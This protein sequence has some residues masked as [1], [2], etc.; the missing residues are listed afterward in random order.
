[1]TIN[2]KL[3]YFA[4]FVLLVLVFFVPRYF[5]NLRY[6]A[7]EDEILAIENNQKFSA[8]RF[9]TAPDFTHPGFWYVLMELP[10]KI[11]DINYGIFYYRLI[12]SLI[13]FVLI[14]ISLFYFK[15]KL[16]KTFLLLFYCFFLSN[17]YLVHL[18]IQHRMYALVLGI[19]ILYSFY[20]L[21]LT[22]REKDISIK[23]ATIM[24]FLAALGFFTNYSF[25]WLLPIWPLAYFLH[26]RTTFVFKR[27]VLFIAVLF[28]LISWFIPIFIRNTSISIAGNQ[29]TLPLTLRNV[30][31]LIGN[32]FG[33]ISRNLYTQ[34]V[35]W[36]VF[37]FFFILISI[38]LWKTLTRK[39]IYLKY[40]ISSVL[41][42]F[43]FFIL[44]VYLTGNSLLYA[45]TTIPFIVVLYAIISDIFVSGNEYI[46]SMVLV[47]IIMQISQF[48]IYFSPNEKFYRE[49]HLFDYKVNTLGYFKD[50]G[51][52]KNSCLVPVPEWNTTIAEF[53]LRDHVK[54]IRTNSISPSEL[55][56]QISF[57]PRVYLI[58]Q[59]SV[60]RDIV[61]RFYIEAFG[62]IP[63]MKLIE[64]YENQSLFIY[65]Q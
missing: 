2:K 18:T 20:W 48:F 8:I 62:E 61:N 56:Q 24:G 54:V 3:S 14:I 41:L 13:L 47:L 51:F 65:R 29:W 6:D 12:Q 25:I 9:I 15:N 39:D 57:C 10:T 43:S 64:K 44:A 46:K 60:N 35:N 45:R 28:S 23:E 50:Y 52:V 4:L 58:D 59:T 36:I 55:L 21:F 31:Q 22:K 53:F 11:L 38:V 7:L 37:P 16:P 27:M 32:Y 26:R 34:E 40:L 33:L 49:Y 30:L 42:L 1:M 5:S 17:I 19:S 63:K